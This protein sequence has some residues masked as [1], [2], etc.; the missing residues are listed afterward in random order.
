MYIQI[1][2]Y[3]YSNIFLCI[4]KYLLMYIQIS[5]YVYSNCMN[6]SSCINKYI[7]YIKC[8]YQIVYVRKNSKLF[9]R[10]EMYFCKLF[11]CSGFTLKFFESLRR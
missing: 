9:C 10:D 5:S 11:N 2:S 6:V 4:F 8:I 7:K 3:V 1:S